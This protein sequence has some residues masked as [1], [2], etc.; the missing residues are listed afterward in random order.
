MLNKLNRRSAMAAFTFPLLTGFVNSPSK[1]DQKTEQTLSNVRNGDVS[2]VMD[3]DKSVWTAITGDFSAVADGKNIILSGKVP[4]T[5]WFRDF[6]G[7]LKARW[8]G[9]RADGQTDDSASLQEAINAVLAVPGSYLELPGGEM[10]LD[11]NITIP[12]PPGRAVRVDQFLMRGTGA[13]PNGSHLHFRTGSLII[14]AP[15][16]AIFDLHVTSDDGDGIVIQPTTGPEKSYPSRSMMQ[17][18]RAEDCGGSGITITNCWVYTMVNVFCRR[19][20]KWGLEGKADGAY[21]LSCNGLNIIGGEFQGNGKKALPSSSSQKGTGGGIFTGRAVQFSITNATIEGNVGDGLIVDEDLR[22]L[23][24]LGCYFEKNGCHPLNVDIGN[25]RPS[26]YAL[27]PKSGFILNCN[28]TPQDVNG[29]AQQR[30]IDFFDYSDLK[31][32]NPQFY[33]RNDSVHYTEA[34]IR[35]RETVEGQATGWVEGGLLLSSA[36]TQDILD[37]R[38]GRFGYPSVIRFSPDID[39]PA[40]VN[41][42]TQ[43]FLATVPAS[44]GKRIA[45][46]AS[47][48]SLTGAGQ[49]IFR[50]KYRRGPGGTGVSDKD[51]NL[52]FKN[53]FNLGNVSSYTSPPSWGGH[54]EISIERRGGDQEDRLEGVVKLMALDIAIYIGHMSG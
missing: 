29:T 3:S 12:P 42:E 11:G 45:V 2:Q 5:A 49:A 22:G 6:D 33:A 15:N 35:I 27:G 21:K 46:T 48:R 13:G 10:R 50:T 24:L 52:S 34:P 53:T 51:G 26:H 30:A 40:G 7:A 28:F 19:N 23:T 17:N 37:N 41:T 39:L 16:H 25:E 18:V 9:V 20:K 1:K 36:Y 32:V 47:A 4:R 8:F 31:I 44:A 38:C 43:R 54:A 14:E